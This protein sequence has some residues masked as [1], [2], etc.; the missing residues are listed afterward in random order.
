VKDKIASI[1]QSAVVKTTRTTSPPTIDEHSELIASGIL[2]S[3]G[4]ISVIDALE[5]EL[6][7]VL[8]AKEIKKENFQSVS[9]ILALAQKYSGEQ[10]R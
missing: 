10:A 6:Q 4:V 1:V 7:I 5:S 3:L 2:S 9:L 8:P